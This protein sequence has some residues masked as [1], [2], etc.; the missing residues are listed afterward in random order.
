MTLL[1]LTDCCHFLAVD[2]KTLR[3]WMNL[4]HLSTQPHPTDARLKCLTREH[5]TQLAAAHRRTLP[6]DV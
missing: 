3:H 2:P 4:S 6:D 1:S 5:L